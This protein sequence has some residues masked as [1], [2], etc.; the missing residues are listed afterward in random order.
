M[1]NAT[2]ARYV[3]HFIGGDASVGIR[4]YAHSLP[5]Y[6]RGEKR[7]TRS[8]SHVTWPTCNCKCMIPGVGCQLLH[9]ADP[10]KDGS[11]STSFLNLVL[12][13][14]FSF[15]LVFLLVH[16]AISFLPSALAR[17]GRKKGES[18]PEGW[19]QSVKPQK[20]RI[21]LSM[22]WACCAPSMA[23]SSATPTAYNTNRMS[24][25]PICTTRGGPVQLQARLRIRLQVRPPI[26]NKK[27]ITGNSIRTVRA[28]FFPI[29]ARTR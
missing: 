1:A 16:F 12:T 21:N 7:D 26:H 5:N 19:C 22:V 28:F 23:A 14:L 27:E 20:W 2:K 9:L 3:D 15:R 11:N 13:I 29:N 25:L 10:A 4:R 17:V 18:D 6:G 8:H 24:V